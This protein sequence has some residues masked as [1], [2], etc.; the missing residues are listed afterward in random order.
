MSWWASTS[1]EPKK[2]FRAIIDFGGESLFTEYGRRIPN[3]VKSFTKPGLEIKL[4]EI[5][6]PLNL[7]GGVT[8]IKRWQHTPNP[9]YLPCTVEI[10]DTTNS[11]KR[12]AATFYEMLTFG[13]YTEDSGRVAET[14]GGTQGM[15]GLYQDAIG[16]EMH[17]RE[18]TAEGATAG[19]WTLINPQ[20]QNVQ[21][22]A[23]NYGSDEFA[24]IKASFQ[25]SKFRYETSN[26]FD[27]IL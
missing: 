21:F 16:K 23:L 17:I 2:Q 5:S 9:K 7:F 11:N 22:S 14:L 19:K 27:G 20:I 18:F 6:I 24:V 1:F 26:L 3:Y 25:Y 12:P 15:L 10:V 8:L 4:N 13:N